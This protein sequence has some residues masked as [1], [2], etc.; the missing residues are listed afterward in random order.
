[1]Q[2]KIFAEYPKYFIET[3]LLGNLDILLVGLLKLD[4]KLPQ[5]YLYFNDKMVPE[6]HSPPC[7][8][9]PQSQEVATLG[10]RIAGLITCI[11]TRLR[12]AILVKKIE[13]D[14]VGWLATGA[15]CQSGG[16]MVFCTWLVQ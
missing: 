2:S 3:K 15:G 8:L 14:L 10:V 5:V 12:N 1:M 7:P 13:N 4:G 11:I 9:M 16:V 6:W